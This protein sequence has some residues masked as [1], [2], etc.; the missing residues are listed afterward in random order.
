[1]TAT[2]AVS[3]LKQNSSHSSFGDNKVIVCVEKMKE[4]DGTPIEDCVAFEVYLKDSVAESKSVKTMKKMLTDALA[5][6][7]FLEF[8]AYSET[9]R[10]DFDNYSKKVWVKAQMHG[11]LKK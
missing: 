2:E 7:G 1:M 10:F 9:V 5:A 3:L 4:A 11:I 6:T 8:L